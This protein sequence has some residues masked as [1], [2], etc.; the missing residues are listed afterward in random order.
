MITETI[1]LTETVKKTI[2]EVV[3]QIVAPKIDSLL[4]KMNL[5][6]NE[7]LI[8]RGEHFIEYL[9]RVYKRNSIVNTLVLRNNQMLL[10]NI[11]VPLTIVIDKDD[12]EILINGYPK[13]MMEKYHYLLIT[14][15]AGMGKSTIA[16]RM[17]LD[18]VDNGYGIPIFIDLRRLSPTKG[19]LAE[20]HDQINSLEKKFDAQLLLHFL[21]S[22]EFIFFF[23][24]YDE[25]PIKYKEIVTSD[26]Q[27]FV[28]KA[29]ANKFIL[30]SRPEDSL[31]SFGVFQKSSIKPLQKK[32]SYEL[33]RKYDGQGETSRNLIERLKSGNYKMIDDFLKNPLLVSLLFAAFNYKQ[34]IP[35][36]KHI[37]YRQVYDA[38]FDSHDLSKGDS[39]VHD[40]K[41]G[42]GTDDFNRI[43]RHVGFICLKKDSIEFTKDEI[44]KIINDAKAL[45]SD[46]MFEPSDM[47]DDLL[48][49]VPLFCI[50]G[51]YYKWA[52]KS[53]QEYFAALYIYVDSKKNQE[54][55]LGQLYKSKKMDSYFNLLDI[56]YD[57]DSLGFNKCI[58]RPYLADYISFY[59]NSFHQIKGIKD[60]SIK[61]RISILFRREYVLVAIPGKTKPFEGINEILA[62]PICK[63]MNSISCANIK[64]DN[65][66]YIICKSDRPYRMDQLLYQK[67]LNLFYEIPTRKE[68]L[69]NFNMIDG[70]KPYHVNSI[71]DFSNNQEEYDIINMSISQL[72]KQMNIDYK[73]ACNFVR[74]IDDRVAASEDMDSI[75]G[76]L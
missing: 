37:F 24:G 45:C 29:S 14:D 28:S 34:T 74:E 47:L 59:A 7:L 33:L 4:K 53:L 60:D 67:K 27:N 71:F 21:Q 1:I 40:K 30:T 52:H 13:K 55:I 58:T 36:K 41:S 38:Y 57:I 39:F 35:L 9:S 72:S 61:Y 10:K 20:I 76:G 8:P 26:I 62:M 23:D 49:A 75:V 42:L 66:I 48:K 12:T 16:K 56:Y 70:G 19:V 3:K 6:Y 18:V 5:K 54:K 17:F 2:T 44:I 22:G 25:I 31:A 46:L 68:V 63:N 65:R 73:K 32:E 11:Y 51:N 69:L 50:D 43:L 15:T 64:D